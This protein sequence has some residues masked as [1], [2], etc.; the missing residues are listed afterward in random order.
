MSYKIKVA[1]LYK[2][3]DGIKKDACISMAL[4]TAKHLP[5]Y[6]ARACGADVLGWELLKI[7]RI[8][9]PALKRQ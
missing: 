3:L 8:L 5:Q 9:E 4:G 7:S 2:G 1:R 6:L